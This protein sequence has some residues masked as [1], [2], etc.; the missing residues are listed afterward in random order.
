MYERVGC[1]YS[2]RVKVFEREKRE[3]RSNFDRVQ[4]EYFAQIDLKKVRINFF[5]GPAMG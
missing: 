2:V 4:N 5:P 3:R 1:A